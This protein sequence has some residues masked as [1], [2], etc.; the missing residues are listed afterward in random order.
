MPLSSRRRFLTSLV[1]A[2]VAGLGSVS[3][4]VGIEPHWRLLVT[5]HNL[6]HPRWVADMPLRVAVVADLHACDPFMTL[7]RIERIVSLTNSLGADLIALL[8]D[9]VGGPRHLASQLDPADWARTL[10]QLKAPLGVHAVLGNH[11][12][13]A[14][15]NVQLNRRGTPFARRALEKAGIPVYENEAI[16]IRHR[17]RAFW[18]AGLADQLAYLIGRRRHLGV[19]DLEGTLAKVTDDAPIV[20]LAHEPD[21]FP[22]VPD[23][24]QVTI[25]GHTHGG[26]VRVLG[27][28]PIVPSRYGNRYAYGH[29]VEDGRHL[30]V[31]GGLGCSIIPV[32]LGVP[33]EIVLVDIA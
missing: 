1:A 8:G 12:W 4:A 9:Y 22:T 30:V 18:L 13:W 10:A 26:Q 23:R 25:S 14:D 16:R 19:H 3:Y 28:S 7:P 27:Y 6:R 17:G 29:F 33:P 11:D 24:V 32:R 15:V 5:R 31:S 20:L 2:G 21:I